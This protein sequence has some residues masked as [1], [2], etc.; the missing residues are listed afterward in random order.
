MLV[1]NLA[2]NKPTW[3]KHPYLEKPWGSNLAVDGRYSNLSQHGGQC[4]ISLNRETAEWRVDLGDKYSIY[5]IRLHYA[6]GMNPWGKVISFHKIGS[7]K[8]AGVENI[9]TRT[10]NHICIL[11]SKRLIFVLNNKITLINCQ[12][13]C[14]F[15]RS[16]ILTA[17][18]LLQILYIEHLFLWY[19][20]GINNILTAV[21]LGFSVYISNTTDKENG[22]LC[23]RDTTYTKSTIPNP[24]NVTCP[25]H[26]RY[27]I[28]F[29]NRTHH[30]Y[31]TDYSLHAA[32]DLCE[33]Q[34]YGKPINIGNAYANGDLVNY[35]N[36]S[37]LNLFLIKNGIKWGYAYKEIAKTEL[38]CHR[39]FCSKHIPK[40]C[41]SSQTILIIIHDM[42]KIFTS[43]TTSI[44]QA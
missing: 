43:R 17:L 13:L 41:N 44:R 1:V 18:L 40:L 38:S 36:L 2:L 35:R 7:Y 28:Y 42:N 11:N 33:V 27:V 24:V 5:H 8:I 4:A 30:P 37:S 12:K 31:P 26:G 3:Q 15:W 9:Y 21:F 14:L 23:F 34:V 10:Y 29:N 25:Y 6:Q 32:S 22:V 16:S 19:F 39:L 20:K